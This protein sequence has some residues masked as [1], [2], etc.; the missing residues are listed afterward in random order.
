MNTSAWKETIRS[1]YMQGKRQNT[2]SKNILSLAAKINKVQSQNTGTHSFGKKKQ[3]PKL[4]HRNA[5]FQKKK[6]SPKLEHRNRQNRIRKK[7]LKDSARLCVKKEFS[8]HR[9]ADFEKKEKNRNSVVG[10]D[11]P[12]CQRLKLNISQCGG[13]SNAY[14]TQ[15]ST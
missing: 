7:S 3:S 13:C 5:Q 6:Q 8:E 11:K 1:K 2:F 14:A 12:S 15:T 4:E 10:D 9:N